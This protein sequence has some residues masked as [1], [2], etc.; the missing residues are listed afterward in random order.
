MNAARRDINWPVVLAV[1]AALSVA[2]SVGTPDTNGEN[3]GNWFFAKTF[4]EDFK[5]ITRTKAPLYQVYLSLFTWLPYP[6]VAVVFHSWSTIEHDPHYS[7][8]LG[9]HGQFDCGTTK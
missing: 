2:L 8:D 3:I 9:S 1:G 6:A 4:F 7:T 5:F